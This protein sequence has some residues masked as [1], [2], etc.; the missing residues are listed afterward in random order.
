MLLPQAPVQ[1]CLGT[2]S[3]REKLER[4]RGTG[5]VSDDPAETEE[6]E[7]TGEAH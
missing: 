1:M 4:S 6:P 2:A 3:L 7:V 5:G